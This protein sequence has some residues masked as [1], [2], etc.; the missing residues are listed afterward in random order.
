MP[1]KRK[2][3]WEALK[4]EYA[5]DATAT[6]VSIAKKYSIPRTTVEWH[7]RRHHWR[8]ERRR[9][10]AKVVEKSVRTNAEKLRECNEQH[11]KES[12]QL[13]ILLFKTIVALDQNGTADL[14]PKT[15]ASDVAAA[16]RA[17]VEL[18]KSERLALGASTESVDSTAKVTSKFDGMTLDEMKAKAK[19][20]STELGLTK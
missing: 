9:Y 16:T 10:S 4:R 14:K 8:D 5:A 7:V 2:V 12:R 1:H 20:L 15:Y 18:Y 17:I 3:D 19:A 6:T 13:R 11:I